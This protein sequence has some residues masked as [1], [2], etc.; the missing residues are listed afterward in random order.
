MSIARPTSRATRGAR[1][2]QKNVLS[3][4]EGVIIRNM[5]KGP[6]PR[7]SIVVAIFH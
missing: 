4:V 3:R 6:E 5:A 2:S 7:R 1:A